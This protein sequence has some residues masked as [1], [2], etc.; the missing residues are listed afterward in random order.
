MNKKIIT[1][2]LL[3]LSLTSF[4]AEKLRKPASVIPVSVQ[5]FCLNLTKATLGLS[6]Q[7]N[8]DPEMENLSLRVQ[9]VTEASCQAITSRDLRDLH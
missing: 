7:I 2:A 4:G 8:K 9:A 3:G 6:V 1:I 5:S